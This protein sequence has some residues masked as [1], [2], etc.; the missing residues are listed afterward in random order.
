MNMKWK[1]KRAA[2]SARFGAQRALE[3]LQ[4][5]GRDL[6]F[7]VASG[8]SEIAPPS[9][10]LSS[11][12]HQLVKHRFSRLGE[13]VR[14]LSPRRKRPVPEDTDDSWRK[15][16]ERFRALF[17]HASVGMAVLAIDGQYLL[18][19]DRFSDLLGFTRAEMTTRSCEQMTHPADLKQDAASFER[20]LAGQVDS[21][22]LE[23]RFV[24]R[25]GTYLWCRITRSLVRS[26]H[27]K[28]ECYLTVVED[29]GER[30]R[31]EEALRGSEERYRFLFD[32][33]PQAMWVY[34]PQT[35]T[36]LAVNEV[37]TQRYGYSRP[38]F[39]GMTLSDGHPGDEPSSN[40]NGYVDVSSSSESDVLGAWRLRK[41]DG[42]LIDVEISSR[43]M[44]FGDRQ[45]RLVIAHD[46]TERKVAEDE[47]KKLQAT[48]EMSTLEWQLTFDAIESPL[49]IFDLD[50][51]LTKMNRAARDLPRDRDASL[52]DLTIDNLGSSP[53]WQKAA[54]LMRLI[55][56]SRV[57]AS[58]EARDE[59]TSRSWELA[60]TLAVLPG[61]DDER[62]ILA[63]A[64]MTHI[65]EL[66]ASLHRSEAMSMLGS[67]VSGVAHE[68]R[69]PLFGISSTLD[70]FEA[71]FGHKEVDQRYLVVL[72][73]EVNRLN[74]L[75]KDLLDFGQPQVYEL[76]LGSIGDA[77]VKAVH[78]S[79]PLAKRAQVK[80]VTKVRPRLARVRLNPD[81]LPQVFLNLLEN[82]IQHTPVG[83][84]VTVEAWEV[85]EDNRNW[86]VCGVKDSG[87]GFDPSDLPRV[88]EPFFTRRTGGTGLG[89]SIVQKIIEEHE[90]SISAGNPPEGGALMVVRLPVCEEE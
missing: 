85:F 44:R 28:P 64:E 89:L 9:A 21:D 56:A 37:A 60:A 10:Q 53:L 49:L 88:F 12:D 25:D 32:N 68:V 5:R 41:K 16:E 63:I 73:R 29:I 74:E 6:P 43:L 57:A 71:R 86:I 7:A 18:V 14:E 55:R 11:G 80:I 46:I 78:A 19:N 67:L 82:A 26:S 45:A 50:G 66:Q 30:R 27:G 59:A 87:P 76:Q 70:A 1:L 58:G 54:E 79:S 3:A 23:K 13:V 4:Y 84:I 34:D 8:S 31:T 48:I 36:L 24:R 69:N 77:I 35:F 22:T 51:R 42:A 65:V 40:G 20:L 2:K 39:L 17:E 61:G 90:G 81:R 75:M 72:R 33:N 38:E 62:M 52:T 83:G 15:D 47:K